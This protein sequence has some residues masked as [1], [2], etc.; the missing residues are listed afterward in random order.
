MHPFR[1]VHIPLA[2]QLIERAERSYPQVPQIACFDT[3]FHNTIPECAARFPIPSALY[4]E[5]IRAMGFTG[6]PANRSSTS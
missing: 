1:A 2:L 5:D 6:S 4:N 3:A